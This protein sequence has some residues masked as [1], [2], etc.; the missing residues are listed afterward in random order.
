MD[1]RGLTMGGPQISVVVPVFNEEENLPELLSRLTAV[2]TGLKKSYEIIF[3]DDGSR[4]R[5]A[6]I[7]KEA[8]AK[9]AAVKLIKFNRN[10]G[11]HN[12]IFAGFDLAQGEAVVTIDADLQNPPE[13]IP[14]LL[15]KMDEGYE[16]VGGYRENRQD[17]ILRKIPTFLVARMASK[18][19]KVELKDYGCMLRAYKKDLVKAMVESGEVSTYIPAL[20]NSFAGSVAEVPVKHA[21]RTRGESKYSFLR[22]LH[23]NFDLMT[24][25]SL[26]PIQMVGLLGF[27]IA[28]TGV[29]FSAFLLA[30]RLIKGS[31]WAVQGVFTL[32]AVLFFFI[33]L[34]VLAIG[35]IGE[36]VG[37]IYQEV[38]RRPRYR[39]QAVFSSQNPSGKE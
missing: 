9:D 20:A 38:R 16:V 14:K 33:G 18:F 24:S 19:V 28:G 23:L 34:Q 10:Y 7:L 21:A 8:L 11:Q 5:S 27:L 4:D 35:L 25:F 29:A 36:Y 26:L 30:M 3:V 39:V 6:A 17:S 13:E 31:A 15:A 12:A 37:R 22:L 2:L 1:G 32:F